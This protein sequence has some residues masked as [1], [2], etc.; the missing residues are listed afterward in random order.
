[1][2][3]IIHPKVSVFRNLVWFAFMVGFIAY[4]SVCAY[5]IWYP[6]DVITVETPIKVM[7][8]DKKVKVG[9]NLIYQIKYNKKIDVHGVLTRKLVNAYKLDLADSTATAPVGKDCDQISIP[10]PKHA[11][12]GVYYLWW[13]VS[14][15]VNPLRVVTVS[16]ESEKFEVVK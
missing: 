8:P 4:A 15:K 6:Y 5:W 11:D 7:N 3:D 14:Y 13:S 12:C 9:E 16:V 2:N 1:M 10:I